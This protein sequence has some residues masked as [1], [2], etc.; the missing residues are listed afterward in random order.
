MKIM[1]DVF[2]H[3]RC[4]N[5]FA[6]HF[7]NIRPTN[8]KS[9]AKPGRRIA[10]SIPLMLV[11]LGYVGCGGGGSGDAPPIINPPAATSV[12]AIG[13]ISH[14]GSVVVNGIHFETSS[15]TVMMD[16]APATPADLHIGMMVSVHGTIQNTTGTTIADEIVFVDDAQGVVTAI[17]RATNSFVVL[18][19]TVTVDAFTV[20]D[21][22]S[23][24]SLQVGNIVEVSGQWRHEEQIQATHVIKVANQFQ[25]GMQMEV[26]GQIQNLNQAT[27]QFQIGNQD[28]DYSGAMLELGGNT[29]ENGMYVQAWSSMPLT[30]GDMILDKIQARDRDQ[31]RDRLCDQDCD[32]ELE[33]FI[34]RF[35]SATDFDVDGTPVTTT[36]DTIYVNGSVTTLALDVKVAI[37]GTVG[38]DGI[39]VAERIVFRLPS[40][41]EIQAD[42]EDIDP[43]ALTFVVLGKTIYTDDE[44]TMFRDGSG[45]YEPSFDLGN[46]ST[47]DRVLVRAYMDGDDIIASRVELADASSL[48]VL[49]AQVEDATIGPPPYVNLLG[50]PVT[51]D[52][53][54]IYQDADK[55][56]ISALEFFVLVEIG[57]IVRAE[58]EYTGT[59][60]EATKLFLR[61]C[62]NS[63]M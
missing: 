13:P 53:F 11:V 43:Y 8:S 6:G 9:A 30:N 45:P 47:G 31:D 4:G 46:L 39:L 37:D 25:A 12:I 56:P 34:T 10:W 57:D 52:E 60:I 38:D 63:C 17:N 3:G 16:D 33:G 55:N 62:E 41:I 51:A 42:I 7:Q 54:T 61:D 32:F 5:R 20:F 36:D 58:G 24:D 18:G 59:S 50:I 1:D 40:V 28:C 35:E 49:K 2:A 21:N 19:R 26:K 23:Y 22:G 14:F 15:A 48:V 44:D 27:H 29:L